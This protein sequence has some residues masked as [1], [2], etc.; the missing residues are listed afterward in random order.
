MPKNLVF[1]DHNP[2]SY[3]IST[4]KLNETGMCWVAELA[5]YSF[6]VKYRPG[7]ISNDCDFLS[8]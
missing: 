5:D 6:K 8:C 1:S 7:K 4:A 2:L 3:A